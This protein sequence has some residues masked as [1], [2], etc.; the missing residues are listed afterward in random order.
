MPIPNEIM[1]E[2]LSLK[3]V[4]RAKL[5]DTLLSSLNVPDKEID[6]KWAQEAES[7]LDAFQ[8]GRLKAVSMEAVLEKYR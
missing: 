6:Q 3:A 5:I 2:A 1:K 8:S 7:R 4:Q